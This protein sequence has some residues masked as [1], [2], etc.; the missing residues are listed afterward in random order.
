MLVR[1]EPDQFEMHSNAV[2]FYVY[3]HL[4]VFYEHQL[5]LLSFDKFQVAL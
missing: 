4:N 1:N 3:R 2:L 5:V